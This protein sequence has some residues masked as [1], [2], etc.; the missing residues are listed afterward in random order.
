MRS[1]FVE[2]LRRLYKHGR[3]TVDQIRVLFESHKPTL[4]ESDY[5]YVIGEIE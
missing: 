5:K 2:S 4:T 3:L 1:E